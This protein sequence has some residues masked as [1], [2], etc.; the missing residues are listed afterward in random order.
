MA[1]AVNVTSFS[2]TELLLEW[3]E[4]FSWPGHPIMKYN[5]KGETSKGVDSLNT[6]HLSHTYTSVIPEGQRFDCEV[7]AVIFMIS[8]ISDLGQGQPTTILTGL[9]AGERI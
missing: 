2:A 5:I 3:E 9:P 1:P 7:L 6:S 8:A 4:P